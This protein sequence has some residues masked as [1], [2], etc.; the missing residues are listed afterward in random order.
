M[1]PE[2]LGGP[3]NWH[4]HF[5]GQFAS[6][7]DNSRSARF[8]A[9]HSHVPRGVPTPAHKETCTRLFA[10]FTVRI[11]SQEQPKCLTIKKPLSDTKE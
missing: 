6:I 4:N 1:S 5:E 2:L 11:K 8:M 7:L 3:L 9:Q 10:A